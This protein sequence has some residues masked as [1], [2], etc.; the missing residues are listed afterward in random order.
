MLTRQVE[1]LYVTS[2][3]RGKGTLYSK[4]YFCDEFLQI[5]HISPLITELFQLT[6]CLLSRILFVLQSLCKTL[7]SVRTVQIVGSSDY[8]RTISENVK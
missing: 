7:P 4:K 3:E 1:E 8:I 2:N 5:G 6:S